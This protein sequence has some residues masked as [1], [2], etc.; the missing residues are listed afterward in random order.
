MVQGVGEVESGVEAF[1][2][3]LKCISAANYCRTVAEMGVDVSQI[4]QRTHL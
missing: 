3:G 4:L 1:H 2:C